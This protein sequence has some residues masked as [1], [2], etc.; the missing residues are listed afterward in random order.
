MPRSRRVM[1]VAVLGAVVALALVF[2][3]RANSRQTTITVTAE[4]E[5]ETIPAALFGA[6]ARYPF[7]GFG[8][9]TDD[10]RPQQRLVD[11]GKAV[12]I[13][14]L[15]YPGGTV[16]NTFRWERAIGP[17]DERGCQTSGGNGAPLDS[18][19][20][21]DEH[22][23][24]VEQMGTRTTIVVNFA[25]ATPQEA[26][27]WVA[28][29]NDPEGSSRWAALRAKNGHPEPYGVKWWEVGN[30]PE[31]GDQA[32]WME[33]H[34]TML[35][36]ENDTRARKYAYGGSTRFE[37]QPL[38][39]DCDRRPAAAISD[40]SPNQLRQV[41]YPPVAEGPEVRVG[42][43]PWAQVASLA[44]AGPADRVYTLD[45]TSG[46]VQFG[47]GE[48][49]ATPPT[50]E[51][52]TVTYTSGPHPGYVDFV[53]AMKKVDPDIMVCASYQGTSFVEAIGTDPALDCQV[54]HPYT[55]LVVP[56]DAART[57]DQVMMGSDWQASYVAREQEELRQSTGRDVPV[58]V[59][60][61]GVSPVPG[62]NTWNEPGGDYLASLSPAIYV[63]S[64]LTD[65][66]RLGIP[67]ALKHS[68]VDLPA[69]HD[70]D[71]TSK[72]L[73]AR[74]VAIFGPNPGF[75]PSPTAQA[76]AMLSPLAG[77]AVIPAVITDNPWRS[78]TTGRY[79]ALKVLAT[80]SADRLTV[81]VVNRDP[82]RAVET[83]LQLPRV[84]REV[85][86][87]TLEGLSFDSVEGVTR[88]RSSQIA[89]SDTFTHRFPE[90]SVTTMAFGP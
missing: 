83:T 58:L 52:L 21:P 32:Y 65:F 87:E 22:M 71:E 53:A 12:G 66:A 72:N 78:T 39:T 41:A 88:T 43:Q 60:E 84:F 26:A 9:F 2:G 75:V 1:A 45:A 15:R 82:Q 10:G 19:V 34:A 3:I 63:A 90:H 51:R 73:G 76:I 7:D 6:N 55:W 89:D 18:T 23:S 11:E 46:Q 5:E 74:N 86:F 77:A 29:M 25:T 36:V 17:Q 44:G 14:M 67:A 62:L 85:S 57:H 50:G 4:P 56:M 68:L 81:V 8:S 61:Y 38:T 40:G 69:D 42:G 79:P 70:G 20:G 47:D 49:G 27:D 54:S 24:M 30:E 48:H 80:E 13:G 35:P 31:S 59:S 37:E 64:Q 33:Q 16:A 28:Y